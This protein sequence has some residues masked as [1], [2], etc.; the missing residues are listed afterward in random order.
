MKE[1]IKKLPELSKIPHNRLIH[2]PIKD[3]RQLFKENK[4]VSSLNHSRWE[5]QLCA[6]EYNLH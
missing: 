4:D 2:L 6:A 5:C 3:F 1:K